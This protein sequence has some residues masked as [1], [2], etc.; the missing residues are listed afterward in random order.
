MDRLEGPCIADKFGRSFLLSLRL[1]DGFELW[2]LL[3]FSILQSS[4]LVDHHGRRPNSDREECHKDCSQS[5]YR[6]KFHIL[7]PSRLCCETPC[8]MAK[9]ATLTHYPLTFLTL[10]RSGAYQYIPVWAS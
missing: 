7:V 6:A 4:P 1:P 5:A 2:S 9:L 3:F 10:P 8:G